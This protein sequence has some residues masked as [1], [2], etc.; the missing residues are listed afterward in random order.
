MSQTPAPAPPE[1]ER[2]WLARTLLPGGHEPDPR[3]TLANERTFLAWTRTSL[4][5]LGGGVALGA[6][7][8]EGLQAPIRVGLAVFVIA[9]GLAIALGA[10]VRWLRIER[11]MRTGKP[12]P[13]PAIG[14]LLAAAVVLACAVAIAV[15][16]A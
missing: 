9:I 8:I 3:F 1:P 16:L 15:I 7:H 6:F 13:V 5:F 11:A 4:A 10:A 14:P 12:L 2:S